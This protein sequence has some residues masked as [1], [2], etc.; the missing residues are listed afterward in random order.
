MLFLFTILLISSTIKLVLTFIGI[1]Y[2]QNDNDEIIDFAEKAINYTNKTTRNILIG[3]FTA[4]LTS[5]M[6][7]DITICLIDQEITLL[8]ISIVIWVLIYYVLFTALTNMIRQE[9]RAIL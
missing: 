5:V 4:L 1:K 7:L 9:V 8:S 2:G 3:I 6:I